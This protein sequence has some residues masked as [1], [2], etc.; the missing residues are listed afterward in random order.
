MH[1]HALLIT[2]LG[3]LMDAAPGPGLAAD[4]DPLAPLP[5]ARHGAAAAELGGRVYVLGGRGVGDLANVTV[6]DPSAAGWSEATAMSQTRYQPGAAALGGYLY[7]LGGYDA[8]GWPS[9]NVERLDPVSNSWS[10]RS[11]LPTS[12]AGMGVGVVGGAIIVA[13]GI[14]D[15][16][17]LGTDCYRYDPA[18]DQWSVIGALSVPREGVAAAVL[19]DRLRVMGGS[20]GAPRAR[21]DVYDAI[22]GTWSAGPDL[23]EPLWQAAA[24]TLADR[25]WIMGG[26]SAALTRSDHVYSAGSD[27]VWRA[28]SLLPG[29]VSEA[30]AVAIST[31]CAMIGGGLDGAGQ[32]TASV[33]SRCNLAPPLPVETLI[34]GV[35][36]SP[37]SLNSGSQGNW[38]SAHIVTDGWPASDIVVA[39]VRLDGVAPALE[40]GGTSADPNPLGGA[41]IV[42]F[43]RQPLANRPDGEYLLTLTGERVDGTPVEGSVWLGVHGGNGVA[44][45]RR[46][47]PHGLRVVGTAG[48]GPAIVFS[49]T[50][51]TEVTMDILDPQGRT[52]AQLANETLPP[53]EHQ[54][55]WPAVGQSVRSGLYLVRLRTPGS[56]AMVRLPVFR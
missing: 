17:M 12:L 41:L 15:E 24:A 32:P 3:V 53:G 28:E 29:A 43:P 11:G 14:S 20:D 2:A 44:R 19:G 26:V 25:V 18:T 6:L 38:I 47:Q 23:P 42:K 1:R 56:Q 4:W 13:G 16:G 8:F 55:G 10:S 54:R 48:T 7:A 39:T 46:A 22:A 37:A 49:L 27:G 45:Q 52:V 36:L 34:V 50:D 33:W 35:S 31:D 30:V 40:A 51:P 5:Q 9:I 21:V